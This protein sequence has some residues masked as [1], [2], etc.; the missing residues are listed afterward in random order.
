MTAAWSRREWLAALAAQAP[1][2]S[3]DP[4]PR[5]YDAPAR[6]GGAAIGLFGPD[7]PRHETGG[8]V[9]CGAAFAVEEANRAGGYRGTPFRLISR[10]HDDPWR[11]GAGAVVKLAYADNV[12]GVIG[13]ID[14]A[15][16]HL[17]AQVAAKA[18]LP[19][20]DAVGTDETVN[21][22]G[23]PWIFSC[24]PGDSAIARWM[25][26]RVGS[27]P[28]ALACGLDHDSRALA[29]KVQ[30][31]LSRVVRRVD[32]GADAAG[33][34][35]LL[36]ETGARA[37][38]VIAPARAAAAIVRALP[39]GM[40]VLGGPA[41]AS[42]LYAAQGARRIEAPELRPGHEAVQREIEKRFGLA[43]D[44]FAV[45]A[46]DA[47]RALLEGIRE[48]GLDRARLRDRLAARF[49]ERGRGLKAVS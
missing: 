5:G 38:V 17:A 16:A 7:D 8:T 41:A 44:V 36:A 4:L 21:Q 42:R 20:V 18:L 46:Y 22:A 9:Y 24:A 10:W 30:P 33:A 32:V 34:A 2:R 47:A 39:E 35:A 43:A 19:V 49:G 29:A 13:G 12:A 45:L 26:E 31:A 27:E 6:E 40:R 15:T 14:G 28:C 48:A 1:Y 11:G 23:L 37:A 25:R 3:A